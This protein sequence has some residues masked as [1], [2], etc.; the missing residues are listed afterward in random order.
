[1]KKIA[2]LAAGMLVA[3]SLAPLPAAAAP[4]RHGWGHGQRTKWKTVC[5]VRW[6]HGRKV[7][8]CRKVRVRW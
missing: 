8:Q 5:K 6:D 2:I 3:S 4:D 7:K 1:M